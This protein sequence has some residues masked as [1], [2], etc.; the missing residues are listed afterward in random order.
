MR[1]AATFVTLA[2]RPFTLVT[3]VTLVTLLA[4]GCARV[5]VDERMPTSTRAIVNGVA[6]V[7]HEAVVALEGDDFRCTG[8]IIDVDG[9][10]GTVTVL[11]AGHCV[12]D[13]PLVVVQGEIG[14]ASEVV[15]DVV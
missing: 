12:E 3:L 6:D 10:S 9:A 8:T 1:I 15:Y 11:T 4:P 2:F 5:D 13:P 14:G 7:A